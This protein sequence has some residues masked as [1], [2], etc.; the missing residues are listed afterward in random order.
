M[1]PQKTEF[2]MFIVILAKK[3]F[4]QCKVLNVLSATR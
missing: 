2:D 3:N 1:C 4:S